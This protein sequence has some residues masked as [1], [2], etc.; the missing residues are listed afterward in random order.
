[1]WALPTWLLAKAK[2]KAHPIG[3]PPSL[4][5]EFCKVEK[6]IKI[7]NLQKTLALSPESQWH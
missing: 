5:R 1:M 4:P 3:N 2:E 7:Q 6:S